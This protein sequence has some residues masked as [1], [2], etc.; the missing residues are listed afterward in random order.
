[1]HRYVGAAGLALLGA[2][3]AF[4]GGVERTTQSTGILFQDGNYVEFTFGHLFADI[5]GTQAFAVGPTS[6]AGASSGDMT[7]D[8]T[9]A[10]LGFKTRLNDRMDA[11][12]VLD[13][14][15][16]AAVDYG[17]DTGYLYGGSSL[18][19]GGSTANLES[20]A[21]TAMLR[22][23]LD[24]GIS[25]FGGL[26]MLKV[27]GDV[28][29][30]NGYTLDTSTETDLGYLLGVAYERPEI[31][32]R[33]ALTYNSAITTDF[34]A[35]EAAPVDGVPATMTD[36]TTEFPQSVNLEFQTGIARDTLVFGSVRWVDWSEFQIAPTI[37]VAGVGEPLVSFDEDRITY[38][39][40]VGRR[41]SDHWSGAITA[42]HEP[43]NGGFAGNLG[44]RDGLTSLGLAAT[45]TT[46]KVEITG[47]V[48]YFW[49]GDAKTKPPP[50]L[51]APA[52]T[53]FGQFEDNE[54]LGV[55]VKVAYRF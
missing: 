49:I 30:F 48:R 24:G 32:L 23:R 12:L 8:F 34:G 38:Q 37:Y 21:A 27:S 52:G 25:V 36:F 17:P 28:G 26:R 11:A 1:M 13:S 51:G 46:G 39:I 35:T 20:Q 3:A 19:F 55:G 9:A 22:Y 15:F 53:T 5:S 18:A 50:A 6:P 2:G 44:P 43:Q 16:G 4:A 40:G 42:S 29:L 7:G 41:F 14:P 47:A 31:A 54:G 10:S 45:Y 33:V